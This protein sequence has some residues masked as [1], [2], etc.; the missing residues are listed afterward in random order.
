MSRLADY[1][2]MSPHSVLFN[3]IVDREDQSRT[4]SPALDMHAP[5]KSSLSSSLLLRPSNA[6]WEEGQLWVY[7]ALATL[8][9]C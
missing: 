2:P 7:C 8:A 6:Y 3:T 1:S 5:R 9:H 4:T